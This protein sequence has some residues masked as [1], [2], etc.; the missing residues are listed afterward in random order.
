[1]NHVAIVTDSVANLPPEVAEEYNIHVLP[2]RIIW[3]GKVLR[4]G[5]DI[6]PQEFYARLRTDGNMPTTTA[7]SPSELLETFRSLAERAED[8]VAVF[9]AHEL[10][11]TFEAA[12]I[13]Q[14]LAPTLPLHM[15]DSRNAAMA[16]GFVVLEA[17]RAASAGATVEQVVAHAQEI[18]NRVQV[19]GA[20]ETLEYLRRG[21]RIGTASAFLGSVLQMKPIVGIP[22]GH[23]S[24]IGVARP[25]TWKRAVARM[26]ELMAEQVDGQPVHVAVGHCGC[27]EEA[28]ALAEELQHRFD[29][30]ELYTGYFTPVM[31]THT[32]PI[33]SAS[34]YT[35]DNVP[36]AEASPARY[37]PHC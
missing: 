23:G 34:F 27:D 16:Q 10:S 21:G 18:V 5:V 13:A 11:G 6:T 33:L 37:M 24:V 26:V 15:I 17:A 7:L 30:H 25:R 31:G 3:D 12:Q 36:I 4:D 1:M 19:L 35:E 32:G 28:A 2:L 14:R 8:I 29:V 22:P 20:V 9:L